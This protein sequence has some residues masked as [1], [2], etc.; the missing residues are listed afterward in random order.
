M[1]WVAWLCRAVCGR[2]VRCV[3]LSTRLPACLHVYLC[4]FCFVLFFLFFLRTYLRAGVLFFLPV[5]SSLVFFTLF[6]FLHVYVRACA[7]DCLPVSSFF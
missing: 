2:A 7:P 3:N 6:V 1:A 5:S 4:V